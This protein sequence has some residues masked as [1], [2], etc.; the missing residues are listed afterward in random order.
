MEPELRPAHLAHKVDTKTRLGKR[1][2]RIAQSASTAAPKLLP[3]VPPVRPGSRK[4]YPEE[5]HVPRA[6]QAATRRLQEEPAAPPVPQTNIRTT[7]DRR[8]ARTVPLGMSLQWAL[9]RARNVLGAPT[10]APAPVPPV[11]PA[12]IPRIWLPHVLFARRVSMLLL[13]LMRAQ[14]AQLASSKAAPARIP[15]AIVLQASTLLQAPSHVPLVLLVSIRH[16]LGGRAAR[17]ARVVKHRLRQ[18]RRC[19]PP[20]LLALIRTILAP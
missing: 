8:P 12:N 13:G 5:T 3:A 6:P 17:P 20:A 1:A 4:L 19:A 9:P 18:A 7:L 14:I 2:V 16:M 11:P 10:S 15:A